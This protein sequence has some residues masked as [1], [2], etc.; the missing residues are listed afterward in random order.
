MVLIDLRLKRGIIGVIAIDC[1]AGF[2]I[3]FI[4]QYAQTIVKN[5]QLL[6]SLNN[7]LH[8]LEYKYTFTVLI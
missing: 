1:F 4:K 8:Q 3:R 2:K 5:K 6:Y 7:Y